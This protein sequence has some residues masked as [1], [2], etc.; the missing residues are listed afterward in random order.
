MS[1]QWMQIAVE[2]PNQ[3]ITIRVKVPD[4]G[5]SAI[6]TVKP[7]EW[8]TITSRHRL[9]TDEALVAVRP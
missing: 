5:L 6:N 4:S 7:G 9:S 8:V 2:A 1:T 3:D